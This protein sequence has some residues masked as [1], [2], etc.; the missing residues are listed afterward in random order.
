MAKELSLQQKKDYAKLLFVQES[1][2]QKQIAQKVGISEKTMSKWSND[3]HWDTLRKS[4]LVTKEE[5]IR[6][7]YIMLDALTQPVDGDGGKY[8]VTPAIADTMIKLTAAIKNLET[9]DITTSEIFAVGKRAITWAQ[10]NQPEDVATLIEL[11]D[12]FIKDTLNHG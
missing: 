8:T 6:R 10:A 3:E 12:G 4:L 1:L 2:T 11:F 5:N 7:L 9:Q